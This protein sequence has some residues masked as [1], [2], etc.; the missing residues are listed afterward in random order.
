MNN[1]SVLFALDLR[2]AL[3]CLLLWSWLKIHPKRTVLLASQ[4]A[5][6]NRLWVV[7]LHSLLLVLLL[8][9]R[10]WF[11]KVPLNKTCTV[12]VLQDPMR[13]KIH[14]YYSGAWLPFA[15]N[16]MV[17]SNGKMSC[18]VSMFLKTTWWSWMLKSVHDLP[19]SDIT[20]E[21]HINVSFGG[22]PEL[23]QGAKIQRIQR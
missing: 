21:S 4:F 9:W 23:K 16:L 2:H 22:N 8:F 17:K 18:F 3:C 10:V 6:I 1:F 15:M 14:L 12:C 7:P 20:A 11:Y 5:R 19:S 13:A